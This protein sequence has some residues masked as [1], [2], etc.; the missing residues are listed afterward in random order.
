MDPNSASS[1][2]FINLQNN[3]SLD[4]Q[5]EQPGYAVFGRVLDGMS[6]VDSIAA[7]PQGKHTGVF[8]NAP[9]DPIVILEAVQITSTV[10]SSASS[11]LTSSSQ[12]A[13]SARAKTTPKIKAT[14]SNKANP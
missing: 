1:Q 11:S 7:A 8:E 3:L 4:Y 13:S 14:S 10:L 5:P 9:N 12:T 6:V 2:F